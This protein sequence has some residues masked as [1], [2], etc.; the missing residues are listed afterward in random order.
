MITIITVVFNAEKTIR[1]T[2]ESVCNQTLL[3]DEYLIIDGLSTDG[4]LRIVQEY[5]QRFPFIKLVSEKDNGIYD[6]MNKGLAKAKGDLIGMINSD[7]WYE[8]NALE[9]MWQAYKANGS[10]IY[11]GILR[12]IK[13]E[14]DYYL[15]RT[16]EKFA[17]ERMIPHP[18]TFVSR[19]IYEQ[20][21]YFNLEYR[22]SADLEW[23]LRLS[24]QQVSFRHLDHIIANFRIGGASESWKASLESEGI[25]KA[26]GVINTK[27]YWIRS[28][29]I[30]LRILLASIQ[31]KH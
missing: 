14:M 3:P 25:L 1:D 29:I 6:A 7:D 31:G 23:V 24:K 26:Y 8:L 15:E 28:M 9:Q 22:Y 4:T 18:A 5:M 13:D 17:G 10:G 30:R 21:G 2:M 12:Y 19:D 27:Q 11:F 16:S 20:Y